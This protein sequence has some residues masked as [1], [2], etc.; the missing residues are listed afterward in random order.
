[1]LFYIDFVY[2]VKYNQYKEKL[3]MK[4]DSNLKENVWKINRELYRN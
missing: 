4:A 1:M 2:T 3:D